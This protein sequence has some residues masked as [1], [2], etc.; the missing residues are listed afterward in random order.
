MRVIR[1]PP[2]AFT[3]ASAS[4]ER[5]ATGSPGGHGLKAVPQKNENPTGHICIYIYTYPRLR[6]Y[7]Y[8]YIYI[9]TSVYVD[10]SMCK[11]IGM[12]VDVGRMYSER[13]AVL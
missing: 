12:D 3:A 4:S 5:T 8:I 6:T 7:I 11:D 10:T 13:N 9:H 2:C 1:P